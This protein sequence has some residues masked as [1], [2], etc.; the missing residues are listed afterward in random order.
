M[1]F[2]IR[3]VMLLTLL[4]GIAGLCFR[5]NA[6]LA[7]QCELLD[8][9]L[10]YTTAMEQENAALA[11][12]VAN[13][14]VE[15]D[16]GGEVRAIHDAVEADFVNVQRRYGEVTAKQNDVMLRVVPSIPPSRDCSITH[17]R[18]NVPDSPAVFLRAAMHEADNAPTS[19]K[20]DEAEWISVEGV[21]NPGPYSLRLQPGIRDIKFIRERDAEVSEFRIELDGNVLV[22]TVLRPGFQ[23]PSRSHPSGRESVPMNVHASNRQLHKLNYRDDAGNRLTSLAWLSQKQVAGRYVPFPGG[24]ADDGTGKSDAENADD[25]AN[26]GGQL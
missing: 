26:V 21:Q 6:K 15:M 5:Q 9:T 23:S 11:G 16:F 14:D 3:D 8:K 7:E 19:G 25:D 20:Y 24:D 22:E 17:F 10:A 1:R 2:G 12:Q 13:H 4:A 18:L